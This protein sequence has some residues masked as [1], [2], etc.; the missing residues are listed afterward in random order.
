MTMPAPQGRVPNGRP[1][2][3]GS[4]CTAP[5]RYHGRRGRYEGRSGQP[6]A[7][8]N[9]MSPGPC[10]ERQIRAETQIRV[11]SR[12]QEAV[13]RP[14]LLLRAHETPRVFSRIPCPDCHGGGEWSDLV[15]GI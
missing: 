12:M 8:W 2:S 3:G 11:L 13:A 4:A 9:S 5:P 14:T 6:E 7:W 15:G 10:M 1:Q